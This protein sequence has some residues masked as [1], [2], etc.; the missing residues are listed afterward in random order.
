MQP[1]NKPVALQSTS[2]DDAPLVSSTE[3]NFDVAPTVELRE[4]NS[5]SLGLER[6]KK[7]RRRTRKLQ[8]Y[9]VRSVW[10][11]VAFAALLSLSLM[12]PFM[13]YSGSNGAAGQLARQIGYLAIFLLMVW[14]VRSFHAPQRLLVVPWPVILA[15]AWCW[16]SMIWAIEPGISFRRVLLLTITTWSIFVLVKQIGYTTTIALV[17]AILLLLLAANWFTVFNFPLT[18]IHQIDVDGDSGLVGDWRGMMEHKNI[19][20]LTCALTVLFFAFDPARIPRP[21]RYF[22]L[23]AA[24]AFLWFT[25]SRTSI[26]ACAAA[27]ISGILYSYYTLRWRGFVIGALVI[28]TILGAVVQNLIS[29]PFMRVA[30]DDPTMLTG[31][32][33]I[34]TALWRYYEVTPIFGAGYGSFWDIGPMSPIFQF[35]RGWLLTIAQGHNGYLDLLVTIGP[36]G[37]GLCVY[38]AFIWPLLRL[39]NWK[40]NDAQA[41]AMLL[42]V[43]VFLIGHN[44]TEST[45]FDRDAIG[46]VF[47][48]VTVALIFLMTTPGARVLTGNSDLLAW[49]VRGEKKQEP[50][51]D[52]ESPR[53]NKPRRRSSRSGSSGAVSGSSR[54]SH[55]RA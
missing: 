53:N 10:V 54:R 52:R 44:A 50:D 38:A 46:Q 2:V 35:G 7:P 37:A 5:S 14:A 1:E 13:T 39:L 49:A 28:G 9:P 11:I 4:S 31:R 20:G 18:G 26:A 23:A 42:S 30:I 33:L 34:W 45:L 47:I 29:D 6:S 24:G 51:D 17:R 40:R 55:R 12:A 27:L 19:A 3:V 22:L 15:L 32:T 43:I 48:M 25:H 8:S 41:G 16:L 21:I 36:I